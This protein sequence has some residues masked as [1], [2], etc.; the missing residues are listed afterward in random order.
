VP[1]SPRGERV[2]RGTYEIDS[3]TSKAI[4]DLLGRLQSLRRCQ[5]PWQ[6]KQQVGRQRSAL[7]CE[8]DKQL[9]H[10]PSTAAS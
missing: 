10:L 5:N 3:G 7:I 8:E 2:S 9:R 1:P 6:L 4:E